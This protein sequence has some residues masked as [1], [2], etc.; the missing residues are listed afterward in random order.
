MGFEINFL[1]SIQL[2]RNL[3]VHVLTSINQDNNAKNQVIT[4]TS[5]LR[6]KYY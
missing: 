1:D 2:K 4:R 6:K 5:I 3:Y